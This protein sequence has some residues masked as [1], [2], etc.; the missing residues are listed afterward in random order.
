MENNAKGM[1]TPHNFQIDIDSFSTNQ[2]LVVRSLYLNFLDYENDISLSIG[3]N[4]SCGGKWVEV[5]KT[6]C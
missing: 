6:F 1:R 4:N 5:L 3:W 2:D